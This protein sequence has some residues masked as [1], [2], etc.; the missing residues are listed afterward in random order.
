[1]E[2]I[3]WHIYEEARGGAGRMLMS[4]FNKGGSR[5]ERSTGEMLVFSSLVALVSIAAALVAGHY[6]F[7]VMMSVFLAVL[8]VS[9]RELAK[10]GAG[11]DDGAQ[12]PGAGLESEAKRAHDAALEGGE[13]IEEE[14]CNEV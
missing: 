11:E 2:K 8:L 1:M 9:G 5:K 12:V 13:E 10:H 6:F 3:S 14:D 7:A 4:I